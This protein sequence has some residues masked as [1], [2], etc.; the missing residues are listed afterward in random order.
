V[1][2]PVQPIEQK[3]SWLTN[4]MLAFLAP[5]ATYI[6][7]RSSPILFPPFMRLCMFTTDPGPFIEAR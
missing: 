5:P 1:I 4:N 3:I 2:S 7:F 6:F